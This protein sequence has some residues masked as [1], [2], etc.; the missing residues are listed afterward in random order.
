MP[1]G[2]RDSARFGEPCAMYWQPVLCGVPQ[3]VN[4]LD[5]TECEQLQ[6]YKSVGRLFLGTTDNMRFRKCAAVLQTPASVPAIILV[7]LTTRLA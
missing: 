3:T 5:P 4:L 7:P 1:A 6:E 2:F